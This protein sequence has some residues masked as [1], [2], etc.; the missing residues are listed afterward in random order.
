[1]RAIA[2]WEA[3]VIWPLAV[4]VILLAGCGDEAQPI[5]STPKCTK[6]VDIVCT[7]VDGLR[8]CRAV[9]VCR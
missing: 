2:P 7:V 3:D 8:S 4:A 9:T 1:V 5:A 6:E